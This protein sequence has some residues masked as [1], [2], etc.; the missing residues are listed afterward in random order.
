MVLT[1][2]R[3]EG[4]DCEFIRARFELGGGCRG[5]DGCVESVE[6]FNLV[7]F[8]AGS[9]GLGVVEKSGKDCLCLI[10][11]IS[12]QSPSS[13]GCTAL[14]V[15][16]LRGFRTSSTSTFANIFGSPTTKPSL[17]GRT[18]ASNRFTSGSSV[19]SVGDE[20]R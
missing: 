18:I 15:A 16:I 11:T 20:E 7:L 5:E 14:M 10:V 1:V 17:F 12:D 3:L 19:S 9:D 2:C 4:N 6:R 8:L 13:F